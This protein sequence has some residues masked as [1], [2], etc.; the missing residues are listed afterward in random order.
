MGVA[1]AV[2]VAV[3]LGD[4]FLIFVFS[5]NPA[6]ASSCST[7]P[8]PTQQQQAQ[9]CR[10]L[11][12]ALL[13]RPSSAHRLRCLMRSG[14]KPDL[15]RFLHR[16]ISVSSRVINRPCLRCW[17]WLW[18]CVVVTSVAK[19]LVF[20][21]KPVALAFTVSLAVRGDGLAD[22]DVD[23]RNDSSKGRGTD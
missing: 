5:F 8:T 10:A 7:S 16:I 18:L 14:Y 23:E 20:F 13:S 15:S 22:V 17:S 12:V 4:L 3:V 21:A 1:V 6:H 9:P 2:A 11:F 19:T